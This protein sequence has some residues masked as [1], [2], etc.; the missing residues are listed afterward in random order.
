MIKQQSK[1]VPVRALE[2]IKVPVMHCSIDE[3]FPLEG[4]M[5]HPSVLGVPEGVPT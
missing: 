1:V 5:A 3:I 4:R 2:C